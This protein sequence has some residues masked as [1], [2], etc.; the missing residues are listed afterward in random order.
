[1]R[2]LL[3][4]DSLFMRKILKDMLAELGYTDVAEAALGK[5]ALDEFSKKKPDMVLLDIILPDTSGDEVLKKM[6]ETNPKAKVIMVTAVGQ[7][8]M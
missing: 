1:M 7:K 3:V 6:R 2:I 5:E 4:D 8:S